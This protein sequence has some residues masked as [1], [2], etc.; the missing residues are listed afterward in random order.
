[1]MVTEKRVVQVSFMAVFSTT[2]LPETEM[3]WFSWVHQ[4]LSPPL[5]VGKFGLR[6]NY[7]ILPRLS[8]YAVK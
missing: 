8:P 7:F 6:L 2:D 4:M 5:K 1:M 3:V